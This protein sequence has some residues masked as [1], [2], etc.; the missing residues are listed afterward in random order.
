MYINILNE[1]K[2]PV[3]NTTGPLFGVSIFTEMYGVLKN[4]KDLNIEITTLEE[5]IAKKKEYEAKKNAEEADILIAKEETV[6]INDK[7][8]IVIEEEPVIEDVVEV[9]ESV[10][11]KPIDS[12]TIP[13]ILD[14]SVFEPAVEI[15]EFDTAID[16]ILDNTDINADMPCKLENDRSTKIRKYRETTLQGMKKK[17]LAKILVDRGYEVGKFSPKYYDTAEKLIAKILKTQ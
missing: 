12:D 2:L 13:V 17:D 9:V 15:D 4:N 10:V 11:E 1:G 14:I 7:V 8:N 16:D 5:A 3:F 6:D